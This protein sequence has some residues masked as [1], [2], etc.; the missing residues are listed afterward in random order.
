M[1]SFDTQVQI[2]ETIPNCS[3]C[4]KP[5]TGETRNGLHTECDEAFSAELEEAFPDE[6]PILPIPA[7]A[8]P[9]IE[10][11]WLEDLD[12]LADCV[13]PNKD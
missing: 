7:D 6:Y 9:V 3:Y 11:D 10:F 8:E 1:N 4:D 5:L 12:A 13:W 2:E